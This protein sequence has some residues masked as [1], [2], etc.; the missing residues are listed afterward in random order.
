MSRRLAVL[1]SY[2]SILR[3]TRYAFGD[4][5]RMRTA[6]H[7]EIRKQFELGRS[8]LREGD[9]LDFEDIDK[10]LEHAAGVTLI[11]QS[12]VAQGVKVE[13]SSKTEIDGS[14]T[15]DGSNVETDQGVYK[16]K[17]H[18][19]SELGDNESVKGGKTNLSGRL[20]RVSWTQ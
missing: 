5:L 10:R 14:Q 20:K 6:S 9:P 4:D 8:E 3:A 11:L 18:K 15:A 16:I 2:R 13:D 19:Y 12:N 17:L 1:H 7:S